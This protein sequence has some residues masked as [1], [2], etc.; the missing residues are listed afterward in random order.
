[1]TPFWPAHLS[2]LGRAFVH[3]SNHA[4]IR[5]FSSN[6][7]ASSSTTT[8]IHMSAQSPLMILHVASGWSTILNIGC[9]MNGKNLDS[10]YQCLVVHL[11]C[12]SIRS[13]R[14]FCTCAMQTA[15]SFHQI[16][17]LLQRPQSRHLLMALSALA[18]PH[19]RDGYRHILMI[20]NC[21]QFGTSR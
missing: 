12:S 14:I 18:F 21:A 17:L 20:Q 10:T 15:K 3:H 7:L 16:S 1:M 2:S 5:T 8:T 11:P 13:I 4:L 6:S 9:H 19:G